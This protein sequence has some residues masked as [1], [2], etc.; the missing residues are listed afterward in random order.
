MYNLKLIKKIKKNFYDSIIYAVPHDKIK[1]TGFKKILES[2]K[3]CSVI[4]DVKS[5]IPAHLTD[6]RL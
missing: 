1:K 4:Y 6:G 5:I 3:K 2:A